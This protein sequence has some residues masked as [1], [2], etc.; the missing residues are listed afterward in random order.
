MGQGYIA[1]QGH[2]VG[3]F[4]ELAVAVICHISG[5]CFCGL[6]ALEKVSI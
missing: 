2:G 1:G 3:G 4:G 5:A 6:A